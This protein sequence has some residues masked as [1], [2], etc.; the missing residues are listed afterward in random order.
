MLAAAEE[1]L[2]AGMKLFC[3]HH[4]L[5]ATVNDEPPEGVSHSKLVR[6]RARLFATGKTNM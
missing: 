5:L 3:I 6:S 2:E 1:D 4:M